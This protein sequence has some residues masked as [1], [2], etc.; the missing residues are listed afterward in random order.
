[1]YN[2]KGFF[3]ILIVC[4]LASCSSKNQLVYLGDYDRYSQK[5]IEHSSVLTTKNSYEIQIGDI[6][7]IDVSSMIPEAAS[8]YNKSYKRVQNT[9][10]LQAMILD[11]YRVNDSCEIIYP[12]LGVLDVK[13]LSLQELEKQ[14]SNLLVDGGHLK[15]P[16][17]KVSRLNFKFT[18]IGEVNSPGTFSSLDENINLFQALGYAGDLNINGK[19]KDVILLREEKGLQKIYNVNL[20]KSDI[21]KKPYFYIKNNDVIIVEPNFSK[22]KSAGFIGSPASIASISSLL[23]SITLLLINN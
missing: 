21:I 17:V 4:F 18:V 11:G 9:P 16:T 14:I 8:I 7:K 5:N 23:L 3:S 13:N 22:V 6:L 12:V 1:M 15:N 20:T 19:R 10:N 2:K